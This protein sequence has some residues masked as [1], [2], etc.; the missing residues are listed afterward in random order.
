MAIGLLEHQKNENKGK[1]GNEKLSIFH[2]CAHFYAIGREKIRK[3]I[4]KSGNLLDKINVLEYNNQG[5]D[6]MRY[7]VLYYIRNHSKF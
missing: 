3:N 2:F 7:N 4:K 1:M 6:I 5:Y